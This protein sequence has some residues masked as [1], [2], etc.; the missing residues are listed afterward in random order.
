MHGT[1]RR[2][3]RSGHSGVPLASLSDREVERVHTRLHQE[4]QLAHHHDLDH[5]DASD[6]TMV[7]AAQDAELD[8]EAVH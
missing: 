6:D 1:L 2:H 5:T 7:T 4:G 3:M 8:A